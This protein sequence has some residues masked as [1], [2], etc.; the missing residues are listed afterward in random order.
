MRFQRFDFS[1]SIHWRSS[2]SSIIGQDGN[3]VARTGLPPS[4]AGSA[5]AAARATRLLVAAAANTSRRV[6]FLDMGTPLSLAI[7]LPQRHRREI[8]A[9][10]RAGPPVS[11][12]PFLRE[13]CEVVPIHP[14][15]YV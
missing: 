12:G 11:I 3:C 13:G 15:P 14:C 6:G 7:L 5:G 1:T 9:A 10:Q 4:S 8:F 2:F